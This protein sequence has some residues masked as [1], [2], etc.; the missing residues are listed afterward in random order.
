MRLVNQCTT[1]CQLLFHAARQGSGA[2]LAEWLYLPVYGCHQVEVLLQ[3]HTEDV[4]E[5][6]DILLHTQ[7][8]IER[9][10]TRH[11]AYARAQQSVVAHHIETVD[12]RA[13]IVR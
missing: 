12:R 3:S 7:V 1:K 10:A 4:G 9:E 6:I 13:P 8:G 11:I 5:E 2:T